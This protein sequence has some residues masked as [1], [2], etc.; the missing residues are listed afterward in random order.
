MKILYG[1]CK[2][3]CCKESKVIS[4]QLCVKNAVLELISKTF[5]GQDPQ[6][7]QFSTFFLVCGCRGETI[8]ILVILPLLF[9]WE[10]CK[11]WLGWFPFSLRHRLKLHSSY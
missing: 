7:P 6:A 11:K 9:I 8:E 2:Q 3:F 1:L 4:T 5:L 10:R